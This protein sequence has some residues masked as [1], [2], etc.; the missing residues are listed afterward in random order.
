MGHGPHLDMEVKLTV[1]L[2]IAVVLYHA[3]RISKG[4]YLI[5]KPAR[6]LPTKGVRGSL[7]PMTAERIMGNR[8]WCDRCMLWHSN[9]M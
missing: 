2:Y 7:N 1:H 8:H 3:E 6:E 5:S 4:V 9:C